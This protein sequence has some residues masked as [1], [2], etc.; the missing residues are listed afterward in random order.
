MENKKDLMLIDDINIKEKIYSIRDKQVILDRDLADL[1]KVL[2][3]RL[4]EQVKRNSKRFPSN[5]MFQLSKNEK[6]ELVAKCDHLESMKYSS[7]LPY[8]FTEQGVQS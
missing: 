4:N 3:K 1:Y 8:V 7:T 5:Y 2:P 6:D